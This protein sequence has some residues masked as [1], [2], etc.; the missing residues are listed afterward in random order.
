MQSKNYFSFPLDVKTITYG[1]SSSNAF[2]LFYVDVM[3]EK[4][5]YLP[6]QDYFI[7]NPA[8]FDKLEHNASTINVH[9]S[10]DNLV[11]E[12]DLELKK[13]AK[14]VYAGGPS[15]NIKKMKYNKECDKY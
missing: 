15:R 8:L 3:Y 13:L 7:E 14:S 6:I 10:C 9:I 4:V 5:Y 2:I 11:S 12:N 1:L